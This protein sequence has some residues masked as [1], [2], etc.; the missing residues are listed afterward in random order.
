MHQLTVACGQGGGSVERGRP[1]RRC[2]ARDARRR[3]RHRGSGT[4]PRRAAQ[5]APRLGHARRAQCQ[6]GCVSVCVS[7]LSALRLIC[8]LRVVAAMGARTSAVLESA[9]GIT[10]TIGNLIRAATLSQQEIVAKGRGTASSSQFYKKN[11]RWT[12][13]RWRGV[14]EGRGV[15]WGAATSRFVMHPQELRK[16]EQGAGNS[17]ARPHHRG[18]DGRVGHDRA[19]GRRRWRCERHAHD[20]ATRRG[21]ARGALVDGTGK[22]GG[23]RTGL[24][25][26]RFYVGAFVT[27]Y[28]RSR[29]QLRSWSRRR[30]SKVW[31][32]GSR[33][34]RSPPT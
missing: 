8:A 18:Q 19:G 1:G 14:E 27:T 29:R 23:I 13:G 4:P 16:T 22:A 11:N 3:G 7:L 24:R 10:G 2:R 20:G 32:G 6:Q 15:G 31:F 25:S 26:R 28:G 5:C 21:R 9:M 30:V 34:L 17:V 12:E 33:G